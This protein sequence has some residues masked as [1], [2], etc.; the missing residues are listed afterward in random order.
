MSRHH[1]LDLPSTMPYFRATVAVACLSVVFAT[2]AQAASAGFT[3]RCDT[4]VS[5]AQFTVELDDAVITRDNTRSLAHL[6]ELARSASGTSTNLQVFG[7][8]LMQAKVQ[9]ALG[10]GMLTDLDGTV[11]AVPSIVLTLGAQDLTVY[12]A[13]ELTK[14]CERAI[15]EEHEMEHVGVWRRHLRAGA[16]LI[17][18]ALR[19]NFARAF[20]FASAD[21]ARSA[22]RDRADAVL[23]PLLKNLQDGIAAANF[24]LDSPQSYEASAQRQA[25]CP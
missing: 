14:P 5:R 18:P 17:E 24:Q 21:S 20:Y 23:N 19:D 8:T 15:V 10:I 4:L 9:R 1:Y 12:L 11:C 25:A 6:K 2:A 7:L 3:D 16:Q 22:L 13:S